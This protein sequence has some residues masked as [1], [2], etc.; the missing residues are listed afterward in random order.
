MREFWVRVLC[1]VA[2]AGILLGYNQVLDSRAKD[3]EIARLSAQ[4]ADA[5][6]D[7]AGGSSGGYQD[8][9]YD[10]EADGFNG[11]I[12]VKVTVKKGKIK[13][14]SI[15]SA[16]GEDGAY[17]ETAKGIIPKIIE[18]QSA[19]VDTISGATFSSTGIRD[20]CVQALEKAVE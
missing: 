11:K 17:L 2:V 20:A 18:A 12:S 14:I 4:A 13:E 8:G 1:T 3:A 10:G 6:G 7:S 16:E 19:D 15:E 5:S 9:V